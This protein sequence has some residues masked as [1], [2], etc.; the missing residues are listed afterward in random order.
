MNTLSDLDISEWFNHPALV[1]PPYFSDQVTAVFCFQMLCP[2]CVSD[3]LP[4]AKELYTF[5]SKDELHVIGLHSVFEH[6]EAM[7]NT[8]LQ[9]FI[10]EYRLP[11]P[12]GV[13]RPSDSKNGVPK[14]MNRFLMQGTP[15]L[16][17]F[18]QEGRLKRHIFGHISDMRLGAEVMALVMDSRLKPATKERSSK[19]GCSLSG[20]CQ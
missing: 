13:D 16:L 8:A 20:Q 5:F 6:H 3:F 11:F 2:S 19:Q 15:T 12:I 1:Q 7:N 10:H 18:D 17:L 9:A 14:T 4:Q